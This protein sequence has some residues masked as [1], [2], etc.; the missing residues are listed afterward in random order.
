[1]RSHLGFEA[2]A[3]VLGCKSTVGA[4]LDCK[5]RW[6]CFSLRRVHSVR[7]VCKVK[8][9]AE[10]QVEVG[11]RSF[12]RLLSFCPVLSLRVHSVQ[13]AAKGQR[14]LSCKPRWAR[15]ASF[16]CSRF[17]WCCRFVCTFPK[18]QQNDTPAELQIEVDV[19]VGA[20][21][22]LFALALPGNELVLSLRVHIDPSAG[23]A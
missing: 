3:A 18:R 9:L 16:V 6:T 22:L 12:F 7:S 17:T 1:M 11:T 13:A 14:R 21:L 15:G 19:E 20:V 2:A 5:S 8:A 23:K 10:L 4:T